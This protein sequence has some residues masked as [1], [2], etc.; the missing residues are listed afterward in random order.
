[1]KALF[2][3]KW[4]RIIAVGLVVLWAALFLPN[5]RSNPNWYGDEGEWMEKSWTFIHGTPRVGPII[6]DFVFPYPYPPL[7][8]LVNGVLLRLFGDDIVVARALGAVT[9][10]AAGAILFWIGT[11]VRGKTFGFLCAAAL[12][13]YPQTNMNF[14][15]VRSHP[16]AGTLALACVGFLIRYLQE[17]RLKDLVWAGV[18]CSLATATNYYAVGMIPA[19]IAAAAW[20][21]WRRWREPVAWRHVI[22]GALTAGAFGI[23]FVLWYV[24]TQGGV[25]HLREQL[26]RLGG[27]TQPPGIA[28]VLSRIAKFC[29]TT[30]TSIGPQ[31][32]EGHDV[33][34]IAAVL[35][36]IAFPVAR[37]RAWLVFWLLMLMWPIFRKQ[38]NVSWFFYPATVFLPLMALGVGGAAEQ[39][40]RLLALALKK[41]DSAGVQVAPGVVAVGAWAII[42]LNGA[43]GHFDTLIDRFTQRSIPEAEAAMKYVNEHTTDDDFVL[44]PKQIYWLVKSPRRSMLSHCQTIEGKTNG[45]WPVPIPRDRF[46]FDCRWQNAKYLVLASGVD[47]T[48]RRQWGIDLVY[49]LGAGG[50]SEIVP[51]MLDGKWNVV[52]QGG[53][54]V[55]YAEIGPG[56]KWPVV[57]DG[58]YLVLANPQLVKGTP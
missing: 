43:W 30:P 48:G 10:L 45:A 58:E 3:T 53:R 55:A 34:L 24:A 37:L 50:G 19:V 4:E 39:L 22:T 35:G 36:L 49:T 29:F 11:Q 41:K 25:G 57:V 52:Y 23:L 40:G 16:M 18:F 32:L 42:S 12:L 6:D 15:W 27:M 38:D 46:W 56:K 9:A 20:V 13:V 5:L 17:K 31:G 2:E 28:E 51:L 7:Y 54:E 21:N 47:A 14:R 1:M 8:M 44:V 26:Q 33:W